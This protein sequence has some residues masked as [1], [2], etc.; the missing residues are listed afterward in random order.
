V[1]TVLA[2][3][4]LGLTVIGVFSVVAYTVNCRMAEFGVRMALGATRSDLIRLVMRRGILLTA[5]G[6]AF[7]IAGSLALTH[8]MQ[9]LFFETR[10]QDPWV[11]TAVGVGVLFASVLAC[12][13]PAQRATKV[14]TARL[15]RS[16]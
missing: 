5:I 4:A 16:E 15:L 13:L 2:G 12:A 8:Y 1:L 10:A 9:A 11:L 7:G 3:I 14:D 6:I